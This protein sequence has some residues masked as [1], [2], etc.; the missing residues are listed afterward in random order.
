MVVKTNNV[1]GRL[2]R[3]KIFDL[4]GLKLHSARELWQL[5]DMTG[6]IS[7]LNVVNDDCFRA[8]KAPLVIAGEVLRRDTAIEMVRDA[9][10]DAQVQRLELID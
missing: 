10:M 7:R 6:W 4:L 3:K 1:P 9:V 8:L 5:Q 2:R